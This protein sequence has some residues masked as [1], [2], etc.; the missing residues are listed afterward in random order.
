MSDG[1][2]LGRWGPL[3]GG[4]RRAQPPK[5]ASYAEI[6]APVPPT[7]SS[8]LS[9]DSPESYSCTDPTTA[10]GEIEHPVSKSDT[11]MGLSLRYGINV[12]ELKRYN[13]LPTENISYLKTINIPKGG[14]G[15][16]LPPASEAAS[17]SAVI[18]AFASKHKLSKEEATY[19]LEEARFEE[20]TA[21]R[22][23]QADLDFED[24]ASGGS[25]RGGSA[26]HSS[27][28]SAEIALRG[29]YAALPSDASADAVVA[30][31]TRERIVEIG[32]GGTSI[33]SGLRHRTRVRSEDPQ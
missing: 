18:R 24:A 33:A 28:G 6:L 15:A 5:Y 31:V 32:T 1:L 29:G 3:A 10:S 19:Y 23:L 20:A 2:G 25:G 16:A 4:D 12:A 21:Q 26:T 13:N 17:R 8:G 11:L 14:R 27:G 22:A 9:K 7:A 30:G